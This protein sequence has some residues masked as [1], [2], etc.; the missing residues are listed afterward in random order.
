MHGGVPLLFFYSAPDD[1]TCLHNYT[2]DA[3][4][5]VSLKRVDQN[6]DPVSSRELGEFGQNGLSFL[7]PVVF[8]YQC[9]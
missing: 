6:P 2:N 7:G 3:G 4:R 9:R 5:K 8:V 1:R